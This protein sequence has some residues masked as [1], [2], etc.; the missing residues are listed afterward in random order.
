M[1]KRK[2]KGAA[3]SIV[4]N[5]ATIGAPYYDYNIEGN[6][7]TRNVTL[8]DV[9]ITG[10]KGKKVYNPDNGVIAKAKRK[11][12]NAIGMS[13]SDIKRMQSDLVELGILPEGGS[14][15]TNY[16]VVMPGIL[17][18]APTGSSKTTKLLDD[19]SYRGIDYIYDLQSAQNRY[20]M[21][22]TISSILK[23]YHDLVYGNRSTLGLSKALFKEK[24][25]K[26]KGFLTGDK[27][28]ERLRNYFKNQGNSESSLDIRVDDAIGEQ[29]YNIETAKINNYPNGILWSKNGVVDDAAGVYDPTNHTIGVKGKYVLTDTP[30]HEMLHASTKGKSFL[31]NAKYKMTPKEEVDGSYYGGIDEQRVRILNTLMDMDSKG[32]NI[33]KLTQ[34]DVDKYFDVPI[35]SLPS[36]VQ[37]LFDNYVYDTI[38]NGLQNFKSLIPAAA[39]GATGYG[40]YNTKKYGGP[41]RRSLASGGK[42]TKRNIQLSDI[43]LPL[44]GGVGGLLLTD[45]GQNLISRG[46]MNYARRQQTRGNL[47][48]LGYI[49]PDDFTRKTNAAQ[50]TYLTS[51]SAQERE[52]LNRGYIKGKNKDY[53]L[54]KAAVG[55]RNIPVYQRNPDNS[56]A[57]RDYLVPIFNGYDTTYNN[58]NDLD[59]TKLEHAGDYPYTI[60]V[61][62]RSGHT[63]EYYKKAW[64]LNDYG[65]TNGRA[66]FTYKLQTLA[67]LLDKV[68][69]PTV[70]TTG[71]QKYDNASNKLWDFIEKQGLR[72]E[73]H[74]GVPVPMT[75]D[76][77]I[78]GKRKSKE[79]GGGI[80]INPANK[81]KFTATMK[82][83]GK[84]AEELSHSSNPLTRKRAIFALN[85]KKWNH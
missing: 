62:G 61:D 34:A 68:G 9:V 65:N 63:N 67:N 59:I 15:G 78:T 84:T 8:P 83:T 66:G 36:D 20:N 32:Y 14:N 70:V 71:F 80:H 25:D 39:V 33:N 6:P 77:V 3:Q 35:E 82:R 22:N 29:L 76:V 75:E 40:L 41:S 74:N 56:N 42:G 31:D 24:Y 4:V 23:D 72:M 57:N 30:K 47:S 51:R 2:N 81:G 45:A 12:L 85:A 53:G 21:S 43:A 37:S 17:D 46:I 52:F 28:K 55:N 60:Y 1:P 5:G 10:S 44:L 16:G 73:W 13:N 19:V 58:N 11:A 54:V 26:I 50:D 64:D 18:G 27:Y 48:S 49:Y 69:S 79:T 38:L 7:L